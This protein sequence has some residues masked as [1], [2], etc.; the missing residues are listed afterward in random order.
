MQVLKVARDLTS[1]GLVH[2][3]AQSLRL[4]ARRGEKGA[5]N[6]GTGHIARVPLSTFRCFHPGEDRK[7]GKFGPN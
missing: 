5:D 1:V 3:F 7:G 6:I 4:P 2:R